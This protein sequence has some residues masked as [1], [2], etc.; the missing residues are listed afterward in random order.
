MVLSSAERGFLDVLETLG[1]ES[2]GCQPASPSFPTRQG[3]DPPHEPVANSAL[4]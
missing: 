4:F 3:N 2:G 1:P